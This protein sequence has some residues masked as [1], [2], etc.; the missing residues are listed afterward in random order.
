MGSTVYCSTSN[1]HEDVINEQQEFDVNEN[2]RQDSNNVCAAATAFD[3]HLSFRDSMTKID[4]DNEEKDALI[5][6]LR[7]QLLDLRRV[8]SRKDQDLINLRREI[9]K[10]KVS[11]KLMLYF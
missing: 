7:A 8:L 9:H 1:S 4:P 11:M 6:E 10:L 2:Q 5:D 3:C